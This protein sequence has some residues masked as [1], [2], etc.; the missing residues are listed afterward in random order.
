[1]INAKVICDSVSPSGERLTTVEVEFHRF[2]L[3]ELNTHRVFSR[4]YQ[5][6]RAVPVQKMIDQVRDN[7]A[8]PVHWGKNQAGMV[9]D[10]ESAYVQEVLDGDSVW[11]DLS[12]DTARD[13][14][15]SELTEKVKNMHSTLINQHGTL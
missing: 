14:V 9:A 8:I 10:E 15:P 7:P 2:I 3:P 4:N 13:V 1:M 5:S 11:L 6:S 12:R